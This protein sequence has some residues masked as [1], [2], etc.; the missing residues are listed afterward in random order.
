MHIVAPMVSGPLPPMRGHLGWYAQE[1]AQSSTELRFEISTNPTQSLCP[2][3]LGT[4][5]C[6]TLCLLTVHKIYPLLKHTCN[7]ET[8]AVDNKG[9]VIS[10]AIVSVVRLDLIEVS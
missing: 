3:Q 4:F 9:D 7:A 5:S 2:T 6:I 8:L 1:N 10:V